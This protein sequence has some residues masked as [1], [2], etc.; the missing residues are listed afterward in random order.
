VDKP[1]LVEAVQQLDQRVEV[2]VRL[3]E[4]LHHRAKETTV[5]KELKVILKQVGLAAAVV[6]PVESADLQPALRQLI[7]TTGLPETQSQVRVAKDHLTRSPVHQCVTQ[8]VAEVEVVEVA[9]QSA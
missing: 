4:E 5:V 9:A 1:P 7:Q 6:V 2:V 3:Q 8:L